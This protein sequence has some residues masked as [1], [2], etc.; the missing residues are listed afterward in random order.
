M[1][2]AVAV[3]LLR[4]PVPFDRCPLL[5]QHWLASDADHVEH[6]ICSFRACGAPLL[7]HHYVLGGLPYCETHQDGP[8]RLPEPPNG[9]RG[10]S[11]KASGAGYN[12]RIPQP[13][14]GTARAKKR[15]TIIT[16][17]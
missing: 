16:R 3:S 13:T 6:F 10:G 17:R 5:T 8:T 9:A 1:A 7:E 11:A 2:Q 4:S 15:Q 14:G 12:S